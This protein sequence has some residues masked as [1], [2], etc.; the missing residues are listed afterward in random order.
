[1]RAIYLFKR[2]LRIED[3]R[4]LYK[5]CSEFKEIIPIFI[6]DPD[7]I[8]ELRA[9]GERLFFLMKSVELLSSKIDLYCFYGKTKDILKDVFKV[10]NP[11]ALYT[12]VSYSWSGKERNEHIKDVCKE[13]GVQYIEVLDNFL[14]DP[15]QILQKKVFTPFY[16][17]WIQ[18][19][20]LNQ[21]RAEKVNIPKL[22]LPKL[23]DIKVFLDLKEYY[24][25]KPEDF[26][27]RLENFDFENYESKR[28]FLDTDGTSKI[29]PYIR[30]GLISIREIFKM[31]NNRSEQFIKELAW[32]EFWYHIAYNFPETKNIEFQ[33][34]RRSIK[35][36]NREDYIKRFLEGK[37]GYPIVDAGIRQLVEEKWIHNRMRMILGS[38]LTKVLFIDWRI[39]EQFFK[40]NL[41]D[42]DEV[43]NTGNWQWVASVGADPR[44]L[45]LFNPIIQAQKFDP[46]CKYIKKY[47]PELSKTPCYQIHNPLENKINYIKPIVNY[48]ERRNLVKEIYGI[49]KI[50]DN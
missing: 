22:P 41:L 31:A 32:R 46:E 28:N 8:Q 39:G 45:R 40:E 21:V 42:Y 50:E 11:K 48:Y 7:I 14:V 49:E 4:G 29:S 19:V 47:I 3:N 16:K 18:K 25:F 35:W 30:F 1:M 37:T 26:R 12:S 27:A 34:K 10:V 15:K 5:A 44:P 13:Y 23:K 20:D 9:Q 33:E 36:E 38:F 17:E 24:Y 43:V 6:F 2:D